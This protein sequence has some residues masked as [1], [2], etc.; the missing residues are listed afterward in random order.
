M[1]P[2][3]VPRGSYVETKLG[4]ESAELAVIHEGYMVPE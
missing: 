3:V 4:R 1:L 2:S